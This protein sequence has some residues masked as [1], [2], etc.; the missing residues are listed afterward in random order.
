[1]ATTS[2]SMLPAIRVEIGDLGETAYTDDTL[3]DTFVP[4]ALQAM[5]GKWPQQYSVDETSREFSPDPS[6]AAYNDERAIVAFASMGVM[7]T[8]LADARR[9]AIYHSDPAGA[10]ELRDRAKQ[11]SEAVQ[12]LLKELNDLLFSKTR[13]LVDEDVEQGV[14]ISRSKVAYGS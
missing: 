5:K 12:D 6:L 9:K 10:T 2:T 14:E 11:L 13:R 4:A 3:L 7:K 1:M 8:E